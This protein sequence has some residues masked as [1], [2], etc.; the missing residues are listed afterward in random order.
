MTKLRR[1]MLEE[2][3]R[4]NHSTITARKYLQVVSDFAKYFGKPPDQL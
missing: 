4:R 3:R 1:M 2:L